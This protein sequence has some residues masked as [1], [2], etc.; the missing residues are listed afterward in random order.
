[1]YILFC[2]H[3]LCCSLIDDENT[4]KLPTKPIRFFNEYLI[5]ALIIKN[6]IINTAKIP[7]H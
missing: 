4:S 1:M 5:N 2:W 6:C 7:F 3:H